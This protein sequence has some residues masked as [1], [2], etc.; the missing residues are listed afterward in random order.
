MIKMGQDIVPL[1]FAWPSTGQRGV[2][3]NSIESCVLN[4]RDFG[5]VFPLLLSLDTRQ[6]DLEPDLGRAVED[7]CIQYPKQLR[8]ADLDTRLQFLQSLPSNIDRET[9][10]YALLPQIEEGKPCSGPGYNRNMIS[11]LGAGG[12]LVS[13]DDDIFFAPATRKNVQ[14]DTSFSSSAFPIPL[15]YCA[16]RPSLLSE[17]QEFV[18]DV[19]EQHLQFLGQ[20]ASDC[21]TGEI[22]SSATEGQVLLTCAGCYGDSGFGKAHSVLT[23]KET[24]RDYM[25]RTGYEQIRYSREVIRIPQ[26]NLISPSM[27]FMAGHS[28]YDL[29]EYL[30][31]FFPFG[32]NEDG[33][34]AMLVRVCSPG[35]LTGY[36][37]LGLLHDP[38]E[39][40]P[41]THESLVGFKPNITKLF[42]A[43]TLSCLPDAS[44]TDS[45]SRMIQLGKNYV[46]Q[47]LL[48]TVDFVDTIHQCWIQGALAYAEILEGLLDTYERQP[49]LWAADIDE[50]LENIYTKVREP[51]L[52]FG[53]PGCGF[54]VEQVMGHLKKYGMLLTVWPDILDFASQKNSSR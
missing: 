21:I 11:I 15:L 43:L 28:G 14:A 39:K 27:H 44:I 17:V 32:G 2:L 30:P 3:V 38:P 12:L 25:L 50:L 34:F 49:S 4:L 42:M 18:C 10:S 31:P 6:A 13:T 23:L 36:P 46:E 20:K 35:S 37:S 48:S 53:Q 41:Y 9:T 33:F 22:P 8:I 40:K 45:R 24:E 7:L 5:K 51:R 47:S 16:D 54:S 26:S 29:R 52:L 1:L 19:V